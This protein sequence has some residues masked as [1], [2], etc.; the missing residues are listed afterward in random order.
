MFVDELLSIRRTEHE[1][2]LG[3][4]LEVLQVDQRV[5]AAWLFGSRGRHTSDALSDIDLWVVV[6]DEDIEAFKTERQRYAAQ[7]AQPLLLLE[8]PGNAPARGAYLMALYP[9]QA[10]AHQI[11]WYWQRQSDASLPHHA[12]LLFDRVGIPQDTRQEQLDPPGTPQPLS[13][14]ERAK[15]ATQLSSYF[16]VMTNI[17]VKS[18]L[19]HQAWLAVITI[20]ML[21]GLTDEMRRL[22]GLNTIRKG[23]EAW[24]TSVLP[25]VTQVEQIAMLREIAQAMQRLTPEI[26]AIGG[27]VQSAVIPAV[28]DF[29][30]LAAAQI[31]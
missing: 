22:L 6:K 13:Q 24:R 3:R 19:R 1:A 5:V 20:E 17:A 23:Q 21:R 29:L 10:G 9:G 15:E 26:E 4:V 14:S 12:E 16:W 28:Y 18:V 8:S 27:H 31:R 30:D 25:P 2:L 11:D 7:P